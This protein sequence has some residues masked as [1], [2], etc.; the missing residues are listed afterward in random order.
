MVKRV[1][2]VSFVTLSPNV[3]FSQSRHKAD[4]AATTPDPTPEHKMPLKSLVFLFNSNAT[5]Y[6]IMHAGLLLDHQKNRL[7]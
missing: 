6:S 5:F 3:F 1:A 7:I 4:P 2:R